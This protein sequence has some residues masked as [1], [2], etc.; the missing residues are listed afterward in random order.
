MI[1]TA[2]TYLHQDALG[3]TRLVMP[4]SMT[5]SFDANY[6]P[7]GMNYAMA[8]EEAF[9]YTGKLLDEATGL[10]YEG[11]RYYDP[12]TGRFITEDSVVGSTSDPQSLNRY[13]YARDNP[14]KIVDMNGHEWWNPM[15]DLITAA[16]DVVGAATDVGW[17]SASLSRRG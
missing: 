9:Q 2:N 16:S 15:A 14:M 6:V 13:V 3:S 8:G 4:A 5:P 12:E 10:Y 1:P 7:Y 11:A 17:S